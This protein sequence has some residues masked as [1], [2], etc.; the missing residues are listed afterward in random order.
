MSEKS[1]SKSNSESTKSDDSQLSSQ[2]SKDEENTGFDPEEA[3]E[4]FLNSINT[5]GNYDPDCVRKTANFAGKNAANFFFDTINPDKQAHLSVEILKY[6]SPKMLRLL[7][8]IQRQDKMDLEKHG[9]LFKHFIFTDF[10]TG[11]A[12]AK[13]LASALID[14]LGLTLGYTS[15]RVVKK[16]KGAE[17]NSW[18]K[19]RL[20]SNETL[21]ETKYKNFYMLSSGGVFDQPLSVATKKEILANFNARP[22]NV[23]GRNARFIIM[24]SGFKEGIDL[25][26]IKYVHI[27]EPQ[28]TLADEKQA[29][30]RGTRTCGQRGLEFHPNRGWPLYVN[31]YDNQFPQGSEDQFKGTT[32]SAELYLNAIGVDTRLFNFN[33]EMERV[34]VEGSVDYELNKEVHSFKIGRDDGSKSYFGGGGGPKSAKAFPIV[35]GDIVNN[36]LGWSNVEVSK[37]INQNFSQFKWPPLRLENM[38]GGPNRGEGLPKTDFP[39]DGVQV[40]ESDDNYELDDSLL[41][42]A[43]LKYEDDNVREEIA[44]QKERE[45]KLALKKAQNA[46]KKAQGEMKGGA[47]LLNFTPTQDFIRNYFTPELNRKGMLLWHSV[48]T[49]KCHAYDTPI[50]MADGTIK[51]VQDIREGEALMGDDSTPRTVLSLAQGTDNMYKITDTN[52]D[53][54]Y[55]VNSV[56]ILCLRS[57]ETPDI[58]TEIEVKDYILLSDEEKSKYRGYRIAVQFPKKQVNGSPYIMGTMVTTT[59]PDEFLRNTR[60]IRE[61]FL[62]G[63]LETFGNIHKIINPQLRQ[64][65]KY[66]VRSLGYQIIEDRE[67]NM[68]SIQTDN[69]DNNYKITV[70]HV[71]IDRYYGFMIDGN[72]RYLM[73]DFTVTHNTCSAIAAATSSFEKQGYTILWVTRTTLKA[74]LWKNAFQDVCHEGIRDKLRSGVDIPPI[75]GNQSKLMKLLSPSWSIRPMSYKQFSNLVSGKNALYKALVKK[76]GTVDPLRKT[77][78]I[79]DEAHKLYGGNDLSSIETPDMPKLHESI[80]RSFE[81]SGQESVRVM[82]MTATPITVN[83]M[84]MV[85]LLNLCRERTQQFPTEFGDFANRYL[86]SQGN[87]TRAGERDFKDEISGQI[88]YLNREKDARN[89]SQPIIKRIKVP[90]INE[91]TLK[92][93]D[94]AMVKAM[95]TPVEKQAKEVIQNIQDELKQY[96][97]VN[98]KSF[99]YLKDRCDPADKVCKKIVTKKMKSIL[100]FIKDKKKSIREMPKM[101]RKSI[102]EQR[103]HIKIMARIAKDRKEEYINENPANSVSSSQSSRSTRSA[104]S[105]GGGGSDYKINRDK[106]KNS[107][108]FNTRYRCLDRPK[109]SEL[110]NVSVFKDTMDNL[111]SRNDAF[112]E[113]IK[114]QQDDM[115]RIRKEFSKARAT[116]KKTHTGEALKAKLE[117]LEDENLG[118]RETIHNTILAI[119]D[120]QK[121][122]RPE[123]RAVMKTKKAYI[124]AGKTYYSQQKIIDEVM[125]DEKNIEKMVKK[126]ENTAD[127][128][129]DELKKHVSQLTDNL[130]EEIEKYIKD[131]E[132]EKEEKAKEKERAREEKKEEKRIEREHAK[133]EKKA[134]KLEE[135]R[136]APCPEGQV[137]DPETLRCKKIKVGKK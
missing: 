119:K 111:R 136:N 29:I 94:L 35:Y 89:F 28:T 97:G 114:V 101:I 17:K 54:S 129:I 58:I 42:N 81:I 82:L 19:L 105:M 14:I 73:G 121:K 31:I 4:E 110:N 57:I 135:K 109:I 15:T 7:Q 134:A 6:A 63:Y 21:A 93:H 38:C 32:T 90:I 112:N 5:F 1:N 26:D 52:S 80:M 61:E 120:Q 9:R 25:F 86:D 62:R 60:E 59:I 127:I 99:Q 11:P 128:K 37:Y 30:G 50:L 132:R 72:H 45:E 118:Q 8:E 16:V 49:G 115:A 22:A 77:L 130:E 34:C 10:K 85:K 87:F 69:I 53:E 20:L 66:L 106:Y 88:S 95:I 98:S 108:Y 3:S 100:N 2:A 133:E 96:Q 40:P 55:V 13:M 39:D 47:Q 46:M 92:K 65:V 44:K 116:L 78:L 33:I 137:R 107:A 56:H 102:R 41:A 117:E 122:L 124:K 67:T 68:I 64:E 76:N 48:G 103:N 113:Q 43:I 131:Q 75:A 23:Y 74:D 70:E 125:R 27:F 79:I 104:R 51:M 91:S 71:G 123:M 24:D 126:Y 12:G 84:E 83:P 18:T 36:G